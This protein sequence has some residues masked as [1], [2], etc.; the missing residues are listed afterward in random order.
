MNILKTFHMKKILF[1][2]GLALMLISCSEDG[3]GGRID[4]KNESVGIPS[5]VTVTNVRAISGGAV[6]HV[7]IPDDDIIKGV[8]ATYERNGETVNTKISRYL[9]SLVIEGYADEVEHSVQIASFN[10]NEVQSESVTAKFVPLKPAI[11]TAY[12]TILQTFGGVKVWIQGNEQLSDLAVVLL[13]DSVVAHKD[14]PVDEIKW[15]EVTTLFTASNDIKLT[16]RNIDTTE[17]V[18]GVYLRDHW[19]N[20]SDTTIA[21]VKPLREDM[22]N[23]KLFSHNRDAKYAMDDNYTQTSTNASNYPVK[24]L[25]DGTGTSAVQCFFAA[26]DTAIPM[27]IT[28]DLGVTAQLSR[29]ATLPRIGYN[30]WTDAH[31]RDFEFWG[32]TN[33]TGIPDEENEHGFD[34]SWFC[35][36]KFTQFKPSGYEPGTGLVGEKTVEDNE[37]F[38]AGNDFE[39][40]SDEFPRCNDPVRYLRVV[41]ANTFTTYQYGGTRGAVQF[42]EVTPWGRV[43]TE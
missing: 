24:G 30:I 27:W 13:R 12:P 26:D 1:L 5:P 16:R 11:K 4:Q 33:P 31:P 2:A 10:V 36:G 25:W 7:S 38:N 14:L 37:Y 20:K 3:I 43:V 22:M 8:I 29:I 39:L 42:G 40:N 23:K 6:I 18:F 17:A 34:D 28:I 9:D 41:I 21:V 19:G 32:S 15:V 35:L